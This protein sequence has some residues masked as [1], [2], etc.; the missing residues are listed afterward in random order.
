MDEESAFDTTT[1]LSS[2]SEIEN[3]QYMV[4]VAIEKYRQ[5]RLERPCHPIPKYT[6]GWKKMLAAQY[7]KIRYPLASSEF[8]PF[9]NVYKILD[10]GMFIV[11]I[12]VNTEMMF[13]VLVKMGHLDEGYKRT[14]VCKSLESCHDYGHGHGYGYGDSHDRY[15][16]AVDME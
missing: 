13:D 2:L 11:E 16:M 4:S 1:L 14:R 15:D 7:G 8:K 6:K 5:W 12:E 9:M 3:E 10:N